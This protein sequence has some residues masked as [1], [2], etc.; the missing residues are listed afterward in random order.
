MEGKL[1]SHDF[2]LDGIRTTPNWEAL[3]DAAFDAFLDNLKR[4]F[5][6]TQGVDEQTALAKG[7]EQKSV[8][9]VQQGGSIYRKTLSA[10]Q[11]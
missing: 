11:T 6:A 3:P 10:T 8:G 9:F 4:I 1:F 2:L 5:A 7:M